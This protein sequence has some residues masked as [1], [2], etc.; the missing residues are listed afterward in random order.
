MRAVATLALLLA[1][2]VWFVRSDLSEY[3]LF[4]RLGDT[5][6]RRA[7]YRLW[8]V[9]AVIGFALPSLS[10]LVALARIDAIVRLPV[11]FAPL[12]DAIGPVELADQGFMFGVAGGGVI[13]GA[14][15]G[16]L[17]TRWRMRR[18][19]RGPM[20]GDVGSLLPRNR[21]ELPYAAA[22]SVTAGVTEELF[23]RVAL[24][25]A[26]TVVF[27]HPLIAFV[28]SIVM[29]GAAHRYQGWVGVA[30]TTAIGALFSAFYLATGSLWATMAFHALI[31]LNGLVVRPA[32]TGAWRR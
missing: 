9:K 28:V 24:P 3:R 7:R 20:L 12:A 1:A 30:A 5:G 10:A 29:F 18:G 15:I 27:G 19:K 8:L 6:S 11:V 2:Y 25:L 23:F 26:L 16:T 17:V 21:G 31:D 22:L 13:G 32:F 14:I 4:R